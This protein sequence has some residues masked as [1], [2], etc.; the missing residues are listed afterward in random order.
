MIDEPNATW[1]AVGFVDPRWLVQERLQLHW[2]LQVPASVGETLAAHEPDYAHLAFDALQ[3]QGVLRLVS[4]PT[5]SGYRAALRLADMTVELLDPAGAFI[6]RL[7]LHG[8][9]L[10]EALRWLQERLA[11]LAGSEALLAAP[12]HAMPAHPIG[13]GGAF[14]YG[15][16]TRF[17]AL[18]RWFANADWLLRR[19][20][21]ALGADAPVRTWPHHFDMAFS[22]VLD[23]DA[24]ADNARRIGVG[25]SPGDEAYPQPYFY[26]TH[27]PAVAGVLPPLPAGHWH[28]EGW[29]GA[30][31]TG[32]SLAVHT[33]AAAQADAAIRFMDAAVEANM[34][35]LPEDG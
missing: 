33:S 31:L 19:T 13:S 34:R 20:R 23:P 35:L 15:E 25:M 21:A 10:D 32:E 18:E 12:G 14:V 24:S 2:S 30:V 26:V 5:A 29:T 1:N 6:D 17:E 3:E 11:A 8:R 4:Q 7:H 28:T 27:W 9:T 16:I 22:L